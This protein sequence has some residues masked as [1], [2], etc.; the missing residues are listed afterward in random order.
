MENNEQKENKK[1]WL[2]RWKK[3]WIYQKK[4]F[5]W[6]LFWVSRYPEQIISGGIGDTALEKK[7]KW[8]E[9]S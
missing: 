4:V 9:N 3:K 8:L 2:E 5:S 6:A 1:L 7:K